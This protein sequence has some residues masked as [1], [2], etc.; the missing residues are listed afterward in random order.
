MTAVAAGDVNKDDFPD[1]FF[2]SA[3]GGVFALS[4]SHGRY[5]LTP[6]PD[7]SQSAL[8]SQFVDYDN[9]GLLD[10]LTWSSDGPHVF[11]NLGPRWQDVTSRAI[12]GA[13]RLAGRHPGARTRPCRP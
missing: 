9:D 6:A 5:T 13:L 4:D 1:F 11:R 7:G 3:R 8:A 10:L 12:A 2:A